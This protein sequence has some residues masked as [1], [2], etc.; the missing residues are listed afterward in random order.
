MFKG[1]RGAMPKFVKQFGD[2][3]RHVT[4]AISSMAERCTKEAF[5]INEH[6]YNSKKGRRRGSKKE[7]EGN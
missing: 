2:V 6:S 4:E 1:L 3:G 5:R 7:L